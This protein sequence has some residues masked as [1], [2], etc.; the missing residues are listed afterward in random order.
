MK[1][2]NEQEKLREYLKKV[3]E[4]KFCNEKFTISDRARLVAIGCGMG[5]RRVKKFLTTSSGHDLAIS[6]ED[7]R[8]IA[9]LCEIPV[10]TLVKFI[11]D[12]GILE[13]KI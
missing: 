6:L 1:R 13:T 9:K 8:Y 4:S 11:E 10:Y 3:I 12:D 7:L 2:K 5:E